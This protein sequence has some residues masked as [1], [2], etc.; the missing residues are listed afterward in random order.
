MYVIIA[1]LV[2]LEVAH[3]PILLQLDLDTPQSSQELRNNNVD[4]YLE[5]LQ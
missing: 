1:D 4:Q 2:A 3:Q 5:V